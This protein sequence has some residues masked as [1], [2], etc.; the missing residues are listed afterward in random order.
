MKDWLT[1]AVQFGGGMTTT[2][3]GQGLVRAFARR[4]KEIAESAVVRSREIADAA[5]M[6]QELWK[7]IEALEGEI[8]RL[9]QALTDEQRKS[10]DCERRYALLE[11][12]I[13]GLTQQAARAESALIRQ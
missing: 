10:L 4:D 11:A 1:A 7:R 3:V 9:D 6:R 2:L 8:R 12:R 5:T 13:D